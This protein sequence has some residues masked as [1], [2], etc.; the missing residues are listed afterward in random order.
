[1]KI[2]LRDL[3]WLMLVAA[4]GCAWWLDRSQLT[5]PTEAEVLVSRLTNADIIWDGSY[6]GLT[7]RS[8]K[9]STRKLIALG[10]QGQSYLVQALDDPNKFVTAHFILTNIYRYEL[11]VSASNWN[12]LRIELWGDGKTEIDPQQRLELKRY[13]RKRLHYS[14][15]EP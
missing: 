3:F 6:V 9:E 2:T 15:D 10:G 13:W 4:M 8:E 5:R 12:G 11:P 7:A 1:M 14:L